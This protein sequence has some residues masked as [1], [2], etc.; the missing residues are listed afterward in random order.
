MCEYC[1]MPG[2]T[3]SI[4]EAAE[5]RIF[6]SVQGAY[7]QIFDEDYPGFTENIKIKYCPICGRNLD[8]DH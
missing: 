4:I 5:P 7:L 2:K 8:A 6:I 1:K 3:L